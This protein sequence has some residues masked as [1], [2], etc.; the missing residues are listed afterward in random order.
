MLWQ[1]VK[2]PG[3]LR[4]PQKQRIFVTGGARSRQACL[5]SERLV[6]SGTMRHQTC[7]KSAVIF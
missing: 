1:R 2:R 6:Y 5:R 4:L 3:C 7:D